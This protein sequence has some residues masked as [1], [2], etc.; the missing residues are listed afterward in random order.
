MKDKLKSDYQENQLS[1]TEWEKAT[2][3]MI[4]KK[5]DQERTRRYEALLREAGIEKRGTASDNRIPLRSILLF[6]ASI[7]FILAIGWYIFS[8]QNNVQQLAN[9]YLEQPFIFDDGQVRGEA[10]VEVKRG[11]AAEAYQNEDY[12]KA[13]LYLRQ[14]AAEQ[15]ANTSD[16]FQ[17]GLCLLYQKEAN[18]NA[19]LDAFSRAGEINSE[20]YEDEINWFSALCHIL[21]GND[22]EARRFLNKV[23]ESKGSRKQAEARKLLEKLN[24]KK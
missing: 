12:E 13:L 11:R 4:N 1:D 22:V 14:I 10:A 15:A 2:Q 9:T 18:Y 6:A 7:L 5:F 23:I 21:L 17:M 19:A 20:I 16:Y 24:D 8:S 3:S